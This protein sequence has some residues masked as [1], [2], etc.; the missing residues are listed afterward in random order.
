MAATNERFT[1]D[2]L[3]IGEVGEALQPIFSPEDIQTIKDLL[4]SF[5]RRRH[6]DDVERGQRLIFASYLVNGYDYDIDTTDK[7]DLVG[8]GEHTTVAS[9][10]VLNTRIAADDYLR[11]VS[12]TPID[13]TGDLDETIRAYSACMVI[14]D[15][16]YRGGREWLHYGKELDRIEHCGID[17]A[18]LLAELNRRLAESGVE[19]SFATIRE[20][21]IATQVF[22]GETIVGLAKSEGT[23]DT[24]AK[25]LREQG[26]P[27][28]RDGLVPMKIKGED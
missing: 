3:T 6:E 5:L 2:R 22:T 12:G 19:R 16:A 14:A 7:D 17:E 1:N 11:E 24:V 9:W 28:E 21:T 8:E 25:Q 20:A 26:I 27:L 13:S 4:G 18:A 10:A 15:L 23:I